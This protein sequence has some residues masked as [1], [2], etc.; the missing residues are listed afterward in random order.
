MSYRIM[1]ENKTKQKYKKESEKYKKGK[2]KIQLR[3]IVIEATLLLAGVMVGCQGG[4]TRKLDVQSVWIKAHFLS[5]KYIHR[6]LT[7]KTHL[8]IK[9]GKK[10]VLWQNLWKLDFMWIA[11]SWCGARLPRRIH[12]KAW[13][14]PQVQSV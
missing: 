4:S 2:E 8:T 5:S 11:V 10:Y 7:K 3:W 14:F 1:K 12:K 6:L 9:K 13:C